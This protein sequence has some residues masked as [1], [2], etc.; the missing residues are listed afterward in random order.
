MPISPNDF[1]LSAEAALKLGGELNYRNAMSRAYYAAYHTLKPYA[2]GMQYTGKPR[3]GIHRRL[4]HKFVS[5]PDIELRKIGYIMESCLTRRVIADY[6]LDRMVT[7]SDAE[8]QIHQVKEICQF[9][10][11]L[12]KTGS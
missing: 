10:A 2:D 9:A 6:E 1:L 3:Q 12:D 8:T 7:K 5:S 11:V 4:V